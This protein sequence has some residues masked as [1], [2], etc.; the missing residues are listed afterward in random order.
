MF[1]E[2]SISSVNLF[3]LCLQAGCWSQEQSVRQQRPTALQQQGHVWLSGRGL[4]GLLLPVPWLRLT[5]VWRR[6]PLRQEVAL[7]AGGGGGWRDHPEQVCYLVN[8]SFWGLL[9]IAPWIPLPVR[10]MDQFK[11]DIFFFKGLFHNVHC[12]LSARVGCACCC[13]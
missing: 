6:V 11:T 3:I 7:R 10:L 2:D 4:F 8:D 1:E 12:Y 13:S 9:G 5:Q